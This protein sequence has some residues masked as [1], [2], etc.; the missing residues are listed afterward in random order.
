MK[1]VVFMDKWVA[2]S[3]LLSGDN[4]D[5]LRFIHGNHKTNTRDNRNSIE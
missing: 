4:T 5:N 2:I 3:E 1:K